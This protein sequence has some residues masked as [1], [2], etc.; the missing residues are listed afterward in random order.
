MTRLTRNLIA[1][2]T[3]QGLVLILSLIAVKFIFRKLG[4]DVFGIIFF[5]LVITQV[6]TGVLE[7]GVSSTVVREV[8][9]R[10]DEDPGYIRALIGTAS[11]LYWGAGILLVVAIW[12]TAP[13]L[14]THWINLRTIDPGTAAWLL[15]LMAG[16]ALVLLPK[17]LYSSIFRGHQLMHI[18]NGIDVVT[19]V[20]QQAGILIALTVSKSVYPV[21][22]WI[23]INALLSAFVYIVA[24]GR[25]VGFRT[26]IP[27]ISMDAVRRNL[28]FAGNMMAISVLSLVHIQAAQVIVS[29]LLTIGEFGFYGFAASTVYRGTFV[30]SAIGQAAF[31][32]FSSLHAS[33]DRY[34]L[35]Q[36]YRKLQD[37]V[38]FGGLPLFTGICF[39][40]LPVYAYVFNA[41]VAQRLLLPTA[42]LALGYWMNGAMII[43]YML[44]V[45]VGRPQIAARSNLYALF[46]VLPVTALLI[47]RFG[48][49]G[50]G[51]SWVFYHL[52]A[53][54]YMVPRIHRECLGTQ[55]WS[56]YGHLL[57]VLGLAALTYGVAWLALE[58]LN[59]FTLPAVVIAYLA[60]SAAFAI[61]A[62]V[63][64]GSD[65]RQTLQRMRV[66]LLTRKAV[67]L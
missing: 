41:G 64:I 61:G 58:A 57:R 50:A 52:F 15:R 56:W 51:F 33:G 22:A 25:V 20:A 17:N 39:A 5:N 9:A 66:T 2:V 3:G 30:T 67:E 65:L 42:F 18:N 14:V 8:S 23:S 34:G 27:R 46:V 32:S 29:K 48:L 63:M 47:F 62:Y 31:P 37:L 55:P 38:A 26:L 36:Q 53:Y 11:T 13:F 6:V 28:G 7:L 40:A 10:Q 49:P 12:I 16:S 21:A 19:A 44:S 24:A 45:A 1:N 59:L 4:D 35:L 60:G 54:A 43:P